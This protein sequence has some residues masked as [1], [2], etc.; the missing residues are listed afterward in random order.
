M[1]SV[2]FLHG[3]CV[4][5]TGVWKY[6]RGKWQ[7]QK[8]VELHLHFSSTL[9]LEKMLGLRPSIPVVVQF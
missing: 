4:R 6:G 9:G 1:E 3:V 2:F 5:T 8:C 7:V